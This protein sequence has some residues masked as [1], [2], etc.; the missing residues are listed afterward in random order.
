MVARRPL[1]VQDGFVA[2]LPVGDTVAAGTST[3]EVVAGSG[4]VGGGSVSSNPRVDFAL[5]ANPSGII[6]V[7]DSLGI[8][9]A[10]QVSADTA[11]A[12]GSAAAV[13]A[14]SALA[15]GNASLVTASAALAS[16]NAALDLVPTLGGGG[17]GTVA[18]FTAASAVVS[19]YAVGFDDAGKV[20]SVAAEITD[21]NTNPM[22]FPSAAV[23][24]ESASSPYISATYDSS[25]NKVIIAYQDSANSFYG[26]A[27]VGTVSGTSISFGTAVVFESATSTY[28]SSTYDS[29]NNRVVIA[30]R[31]GGNSSYG[32]AIVGT[33]SGTSI[34]F[35]TAVVFESANSPYI[36]SVY[37]S[38][39][40]RVVIAYQ[41]NGNSNY[42]TAIVGTVSGTS[43]SFGSAVV[44]ESASS[45]Y[46]SSTYD[47]TNNKVVIAYRNNGNSNYGTAIVGTV[48]GTSISFGTAVVFESASSLYIST[49]YDSTNNKVVIAYRDQTNS[50]YGTAI[51]GTVS[52]TSISFGT[53]VV[54]EA[55]NSLYIST[56]FDSTN[57]R[58]VIA[59]RDLDNFSYGTAIVGTVSGTSISFG[60]AV[61][62]ESNSSDYNFTTYDS[63]NDRVVIAFRDVGTSN[64]GKAV[65]GAPGT[66]I[67]PTISSQNNFIGIA[68]T[69]AASGSA[70]QVRLPGS[71]DQNNTGLTPGAVYY[72]NPTTSG[73]TTTA[74]QPSAWSGAVNWDPIGRAV[75]STT[76]LLT[77]MI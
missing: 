30:Y 26:T 55:A 62:F 39:N 46:I 61:V 49:T 19:G 58:V 15:S 9:G 28:T 13:L 53:A 48:S 57:N 23:V 44:F 8:D 43:I 17:A 42:G 65:V 32:T 34:S 11:L 69:T 22:S 70:V 3:T 33:V 47:S 37:D 73:F 10:A 27:I 24:F 72:V 25:N 63:T 1:V 66:T 74:T 52:G 14:D 64:Y 76:L 54:F 67:G 40:N 77:D 56:T 7:G 5:A 68:Q 16:G 50:N 45:N 29:T 4:L 12:S 75:N 60:T 6:Y 20:Q 21:D 2:E 35:G 38:T 18:E 41:N 36:S 59:Y 51:V 31:D 71:Y